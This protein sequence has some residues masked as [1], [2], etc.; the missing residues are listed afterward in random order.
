MFKTEIKLIR[1]I[2]ARSGTKVVLGLCGSRSGLSLKKFCQ[3]DSG[4]TDAGK[5]PFYR[6]T[7]AG[8]SLP[9]ERHYKGKVEK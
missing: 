7:S 2:R 9:I 1:I 6:K 8:A 4:L 5:R 3:F